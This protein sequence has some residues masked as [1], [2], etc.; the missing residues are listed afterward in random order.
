[1]NVDF[2]IVILRG[3]RY[4]HKS[5]KAFIWVANCTCKRVK[6]WL[7]QLVKRRIGT[8]CPCVWFQKKTTI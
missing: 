1:M 2:L 3:T 4:G 8:T 5:Y 7:K 6:N